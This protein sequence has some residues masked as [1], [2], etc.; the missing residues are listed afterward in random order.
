MSN[1][2][3]KQV[4]SG[5]QKLDN[6]DKLIY[7]DLAFIEVS[8]EVVKFEF[9]HKLN[10]TNKIIIDCKV[11]LNVH[12]AKR[13]LNVLKSNFTKLEKEFGK[14]EPNIKKIVKK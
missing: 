7:S 3:E 8:P 5:F 13:F 2:R 11:A 10:N 12:H 1:D 6:L 9:G 4:I 14:I